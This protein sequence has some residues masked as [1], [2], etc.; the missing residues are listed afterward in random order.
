MLAV[1][2][3]NRIVPCPRGSIRR[4][5]HHEAAQARALPGRHELFGVDVKETRTDSAACV[6]DADLDR[7]ELRLDSIEQPT[8]RTLVYGID[9]VAL[10]TV[11]AGRD[12]RDLVL[13]AGR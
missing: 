6:E 7:T 11:D 1:A 4:A 5:P 9:G 13:G 8:D 10:G 3:V 2:P 12:A